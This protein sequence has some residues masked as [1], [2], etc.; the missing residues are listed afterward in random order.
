MKT[1]ALKMLLTALLRGTDGYQRV[2]ISN[3]KEGMKIDVVPP[4]NPPALK[5]G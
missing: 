2:S 1:D 3:G 4:F 5:T